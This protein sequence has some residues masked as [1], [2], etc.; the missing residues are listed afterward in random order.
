[1][2]SPVFGMV[3]DAVATLPPEQRAHIQTLVYD[4]FR[5]AAV[6]KQLDE[7][8]KQLKK[9]EADKSMQLEKLEADKSMQLRELRESRDRE[10]A[11]L[12]DL[13]TLMEQGKVKAEVELLMTQAKVSS[14]YAFRPI[15]E[16]S[17]SKWSGNLE[18]GSSISRYLAKFVQPPNRDARN[19]DYPGDQLSPD[20]KAALEKM[21]I[22]EISLQKEVALNVNQLYSK[23]CKPFHQPPPEAI[24]PKGFLLGG[25]ASIRYATALVVLK[26]QVLKGN[27]S[28]PK[29]VFLLDDDHKPTH[30]LLNGAVVVYDPKKTY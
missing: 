12:N 10:L 23:L 4:G 17:C 13:L 26:L 5:M 16:L 18:F 19:Q 6:E 30:V 21:G 3:M 8:D 7:K 15:I 28:F 11:Y 25:D 27:E 24:L 2:S 1:M 9:L 20:S 22:S 29:K 14:V